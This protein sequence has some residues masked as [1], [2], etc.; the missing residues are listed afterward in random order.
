MTNF[1]EDAYADGSYEQLPCGSNTPTEVLVS[2]HPRL[3][4]SSLLLVKIAPYHAPP[5]RSSPPPA[6][7]SP[8]SA[9]P[10]RRPTAPGP[11]AARPP[12]PPPSCARPRRSLAAP[13]SAWSAVARPHR[14][15][16]S[17]A[18]ALLGRCRLLL[19]GTTGS[20]GEDIVVA[21]YCLGS[22]RRRPPR[23]WLPHDTPVLD[24]HCR[25]HF[26]F[27]HGLKH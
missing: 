26:F 12:S 27:V 14:R 1:R 8:P 16:T 23:Q 19:Y 10:H 20:T 25:P 9:Y 21:T 6:H 2:I 24:L 15:L 13:E 17:A 11:T 3:P 5:D 22:A 18:R 7:H 4:A